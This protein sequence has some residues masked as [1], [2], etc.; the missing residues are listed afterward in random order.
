MSICNEHAAVHRTPQNT[1]C[2]SDAVIHTRTAP[3]TNLGS[4]NT[5]QTQSYVQDRKPLNKCYNLFE[6]SATIET[7]A[8]MERA[9]ITN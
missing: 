6:K 1:K 7:T 2:A 3:H 4:K 9:K 5:S 8:V